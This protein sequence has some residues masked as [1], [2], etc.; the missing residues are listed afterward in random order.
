MWFQLEPADLGFLAGAPHR[1]DTV[2]VVD[3]TPEQVFRAFEDPEQMAAFVYGFR[4]CSWAT[5]EHG[6]GAVRQLDLYGLS[7]REHFLAWEPGRRLC[8]AIDAMS[9]PLM[10]KMVE[11]V[12]IDALP[13][14]KTRLIWSVHYQPTWLTRLLH[15][16]A[17]FG[18]EQ[19]Y[20]QSVERLARHLATQAPPPASPK[21]ATRGK[22]GTRVRAN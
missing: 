11:D 6:V 16:W 5:G 7:F 1:F 20:R 18:F 3:A 4:R 21:P 13:E 2:T 15:P 8:F 12:Q 14:G 19:G 22:S 10:S 9:L 17:R